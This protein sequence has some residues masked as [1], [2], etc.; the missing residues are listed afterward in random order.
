MGADAGSQAAVDRIRQL[1]LDN[2]VLLTGDLP[3]DEFMTLITRAKLY[4]RTPKKD[5]VCSSVLEALS[6][7][8]PVVASENGTRPSGVVTFRP[9]DAEDLAAKVG[10]VLEH[11]EAIRRA[12]VPPPIRDTVL[13]EANLLLG[14]TAAG[15]SE[16]A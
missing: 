6:L 7:N 5:G 2:H 4:L 12:L 16:A 10:D 1:G 3:H 15:K 14:I 8:V 13:D 11:N 9:N